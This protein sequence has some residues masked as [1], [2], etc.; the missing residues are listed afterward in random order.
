MS[1]RNSIGT[2]LPRNLA[3]PSLI[4]AA[5]EVNTQASKQTRLI[6]TVVFE[7]CW[8]VLAELRVHFPTPNPREPPS[9]PQLGFRI[10]LPCLT[11]GNT[12]YSTPQ[13]ILWRALSL[14]CRVISG[15]SGFGALQRKKSSAKAV[16]HISKTTVSGS[17]TTGWSAASIFGQDMLVIAV[18]NVN[19]IMLTHGN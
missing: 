14:G 6:N 12:S 1:F 13:L 15:V 10:A 16:Q 11:I 17:C 3:C 5:H 4:N 2:I 18:S 8:T 7:I 9:T 19:S